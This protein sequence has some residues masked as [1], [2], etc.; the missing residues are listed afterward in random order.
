MQTEPTNKIT[1]E[2]KDYL[3]FRVSNFSTKPFFVN[4][5]LVLGQKSM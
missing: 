2:Q 5:E 4:C 1:N 3:G